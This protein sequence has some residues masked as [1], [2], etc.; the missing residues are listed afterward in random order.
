MGKPTC[1]R[2]V[3]PN[4]NTNNA[5]NK[6]NQVNTGKGTAGNSNSNNNNNNPNKKRRRKNNGRRGRNG[7]YSNSNKSGKNKTPPPLQLPHAKITIRKIQNVEK[8]GSREKMADFIRILVGASTDASLN[9]NSTENSSS[10]VPIVLDEKS[11][12]KNCTNLLPQQLPP[13]EAENQTEKID[14]T[15]KDAEEK[16]EDPSSESKE[17]ED[18]PFSK[19]ETNLIS[20]PHEEKK[21][22][23]T[24]RVLYVTPPR[25]SRRRGIQTGAAYIVLY[26]PDPTKSLPVPQSTSSTPSTPSTDLSTVPTQ[27]ASTTA[28]APTSDSTTVDST[29]KSDEIEKL[30]Q[31]EN[32][33]NKDTAISPKINATQEPNADVQPQSIVL[34]G[35]ER[36][37]AVAAARI[38]LQNAQEYLTVQASKNVNLLGECVV[39]LS[40]S[41]KTWKDHTNKENQ[42]NNNKRNGKRSDRGDRYENTIFNTEDYRSFLEGLSKKDEELANRPKPLPGGGEVDISTSLTSSSFLSS[43]HASNSNSGNN[44]SN[45]GNSGLDGPNANANVAALAQYLRNKKKEQKAKHLAKR[46]TS[47]SATSSSTSKKLALG[48]IKLLEKSSNSKKNRNNKKNNQPGNTKSGDK[49][50]TSSSKKKGKKKRKEKKGSSNKNTATESNMMVTPILMKN[51]SSISVNAINMGK[52]VKV[53]PR[54]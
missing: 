15:N 13:K 45:S 37:K 20:I 21:N 12:Q 51:P 49:K 50:N 11:L 7:N 52:K 44:N 25:R 18:T 24:A 34:V 30:Q 42:H 26:P 6:S 40:P 47:I 19:T 2:R 38:T 54:N 29:S 9:R 1:A 46:T 53:A 33:D 32:E 39:E 31:P 27:P 23:V 36:S 28:S 35:Q 41:Q 48:S 5:N 22:A 8:Y 10:F 16:S 3:N 43:D 14:T 4:N 17:Q